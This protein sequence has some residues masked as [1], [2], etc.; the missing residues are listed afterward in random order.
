MLTFPRF[1][2]TKKRNINGTK[3]RLHYP[4]RNLSSS[5]TIGDSNL[6]RGNKKRKGAKPP[7]LRFVLSFNYRNKTEGSFWGYMRLRMYVTYNFKRLLG[8]YR[9]RARRKSILWRLTTEEFYNLTQS[10]CYLCGIP[11]SKSFQH[12]HRDLGRKSYPPFIYN[13][14]DRIDST[15]GYCPSN[16]EPCCWLCNSMKKTMKLRDFKRHILRVA[17]GINTD[18]KEK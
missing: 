6:L 5:A 16:V 14:I 13:G 9:Y 1:S 8:S 3:N 11:P 7:K 12:E 4:P 2:G 18:A 15:K 17:K 10:D